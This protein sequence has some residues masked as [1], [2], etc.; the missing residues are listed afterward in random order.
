MDGSVGFVVDGWVVLGVLA[1][2]IVTAFIRVVAELLLRFLA[3]KPPKAE[4]HR[5]G[6]LWDNGEVGDINGS[7]VVHLDGSAWLRPTH[8]DEGLTEGGWLWCTGH[9]VWLWQQKT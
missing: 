3:A 2:P 1:C 9:Q 8:F 7:G 5:H 6:F 4:V